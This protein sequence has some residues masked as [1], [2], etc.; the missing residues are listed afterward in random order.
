MNERALLFPQ[1]SAIPTTTCVLDTIQP[2]FLGRK[3]GA[4]WARKIQLVEKV[5]QLKLGK[6]HVG[7]LKLGRIEDLSEVV[8]NCI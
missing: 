3:D 2:F 4:L 1:T 6:N 5:V 8:R 7:L